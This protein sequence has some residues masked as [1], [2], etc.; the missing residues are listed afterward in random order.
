MT[1][2]PAAVDHCD[3]CASTLAPDVAESPERVAEATGWHEFHTLVDRLTP[4]E[5]YEPGYFAEGWSVRDLI[6]HI[7]AW[8]AEAGQLFEQMRSGTYSEG[9]LDV[10]EANARFLELMRDLPLETVHLQAWSARWRMISAWAQ[11]PAPPSEAARS[12]L[13]K[14]GGEHYAEHLPR[15][16]EWCAELIDRRGA[17]SAAR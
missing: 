5:A 13:A 16:R 4:E 8:L 17:T 14:A 6:G 15:L 7:G 9:E 1:S 12:W 3:R 2:L 11:L 10:D